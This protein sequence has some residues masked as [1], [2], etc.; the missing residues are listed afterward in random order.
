MRTESAVDT[1]EATSEH[2]FLKL[3]V[4]VVVGRALC[5]PRSY[6]RTCCSAPILCPLWRNARALSGQNYRCA[7]DMR[8]H[9]Y[10]TF[11]HL[12]LVRVSFVR[13]SFLPSFSFSSAA[14]RGAGRTRNSAICP[15]TILGTWD[16]H[17]FGWN[18]GACQFSLSVGPPHPC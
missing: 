2:R 16:D 15:R 12:P 4:V 17:D 3:L 7:H 1:A 14:G 13:F 8:K 18:D 11:P 10:P 9:R 5:A 6:L